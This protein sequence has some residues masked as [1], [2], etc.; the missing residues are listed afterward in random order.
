M[1]V[2]ALSQHLEAAIRACREHRTYRA[3]EDS[4]PKLWFSRAVV[5]ET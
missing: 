1:G 3:H 4:L 5:R 2:E